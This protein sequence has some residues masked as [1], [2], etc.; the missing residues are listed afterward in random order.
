MKG[1]EQP[2]LQSIAASTGISVSTVSRILSGKARKYRISP[3]TE[4]RVRAEAERVGFAVNQLASSLRTR[5]SNTFGLLIP[6]IS[7][8]FF[9]SIARHVANEARKN[10]YSIVLC[11]SQENDQIEAESIRT[12]QSRNIDG[13]LVAPV[14]HIADS[15]TA[16]RKRGIPVVLLDRYYPECD[17]PYVTTKNY[18]AAF[19]ATEHL[20]AMGHRRIACIL[21]LPCSSTAADR[22]NGFHAAMKKHGIPV[23]P[24]LVAG[25]DFTEING[26]LQTKKFMMHKERPTA[27]FSMGNLM[28]LGA[29]RVL[30][31]ESIRIPEDVSL[32]SFDDHEFAAFLSTPVSAIAQNTE[33]IGQVAVQLLLEQMNNLYS[34][35]IDGITL[36]ARLNLRASVSNLN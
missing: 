34:G 13:L 35:T 17:I 10:G 24:S 30:A 4:Q 23:D 22:A 36:P 5:K 2:T 3:K 11:D 27:I 32:L 12:L 16:V 6:D 33:G 14:G 8:S 18:E 31:E 28:T 20:I 19:E 26:Y 25:N 9:A 15:L 7:N 1:N 29:L 21:G